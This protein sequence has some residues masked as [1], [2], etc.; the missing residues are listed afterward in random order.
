MIDLLERLEKDGLVRMEKIDAYRVVRIRRFGG[1]V[2]SGLEHV[3]W[4]AKPEMP[5]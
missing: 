2:A 3:D 1:E 5:E 4:I